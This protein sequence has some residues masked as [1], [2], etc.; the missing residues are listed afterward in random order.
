MNKEVILERLK[1]VDPLNYKD[2]F[3]PELVPQTVHLPDESLPSWYLSTEYKK[4]SRVGRFRYLRPPSATLPLNN[5]AD[6]DAR[7]GPN[8]PE[9]AMQ[10]PDGKRRPI[11]LRDTWWV[12]PFSEHPSA[13]IVHTEV[14]ECMADYQKTVHGFENKKEKK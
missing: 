3:K 7:R 12:K 13:Y 8:R 11:A 1:N 9:Y 14:D 5:N 4:K 2:T 10:Y 6:L